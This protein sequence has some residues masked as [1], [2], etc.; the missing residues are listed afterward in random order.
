MGVSLEVSR[1]KNY[2]IPCIILVSD[3]STINPNVTPI[4]IYKD[5]FH[6]MLRFLVHVI[7]HLSLPFLHP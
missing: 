3:T 5:S 7:L 2:K 6:S 4:P 1:I